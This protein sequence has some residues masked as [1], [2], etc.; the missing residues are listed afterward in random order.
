VT[1]RD[2]STAAF[3][4]TDAA[5]AASEPANRI[6]TDTPGAWLLRFV[7][8]VVIGVGAILPGLSGGV[9][10]VVFGVY[11]RI[12]RFFADLRRDF[13]ANV[14]FLLPI[15][16]GVGL[17]I[18]LFS[19]VV[20]AA[21]GRYAAQFTCLFIGFVVGTVPSLYREAGRRGRAP[22]HL[23]VLGA[24]AAGVA[25]LMILGGGLVVAIAP[26]IPVWFGSGALIGLGLVVP[27]L[28]PSN[29]LIY[30]G[31]YD[32]MATGIGHLDAGVVLPLAAGVIGCTLLLAKG[33]AWLFDHH[34][35]GMYHFIVGTVVGSSLALIPAV[36]LPAYTPDRLSASGL[37]LGAAVAFGAGMLIVGVVAS[38]L[39]SRF[40]SRVE[41]RAGA[42]SESPDRTVG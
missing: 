34:H 38:Y 40:E 23:G 31:L 15:V 14:R 37:D 32:K 18:L 25:A 16:L 35:A 5:E 26:S 33:A 22:K 24:S 6:Q 28:S 39:F 21:F 30:F 10:A 17:G 20:E 41:A 27:G 12:I 7:K 19:L 13:W 1:S 2:G 9:L 4:R 29:F 8:G 11:D 42:R 36:V 3:P